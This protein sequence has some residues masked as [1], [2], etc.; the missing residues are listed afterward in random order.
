VRNLGVERRDDDADAVQIADVEKT[1]DVALLRRRRIRKKIPAVDAVLHV[2]AW[3]HRVV[4]KSDAS[5]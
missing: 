5:E 2:K 4:G 3:V 1:L